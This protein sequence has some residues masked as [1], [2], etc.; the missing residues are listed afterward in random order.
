MYIRQTILFTLNR[1]KVILLCLAFFIPFFSY[2]ED[3]SIQNYS[4]LALKKGTFYAGL[5]LTPQNASI[6]LEI[7]ETRFGINNSASINVEYFLAN[8]LSILGYAALTHYYSTSKI[9]T[10]FSQTERRK[11][12][13]F[14]PLLGIGVA[15]YPKFFQI[16]P[17]HSSILYNIGLFGVFNRSYVKGGFINST[18]KIEISD[19]SVNGGFILQFYPKNRFHLPTSRFSGQL[20]FSFPTYYINRLESGFDINKPPNKTRLEYSNFITFGIKYQLSPLAKQVNKEIPEKFR[21][22]TF[23]QLYKEKSIHAGLGLNWRPMYYENN[24]SSTTI[25]Y[26]VINTDLE[27]FIKRR[28]SVN[29]GYIGLRSSNPTDLFD[30]QSSDRLSAF[31]SV[32]P[33]FMRGLNRFSFSSSLGLSY[34][35][36]KVEL[37]SNPN[38]LKNNFA[39]K[40]M[41]VFGAYTFIYK[42]LRL[43][44][45]DNHNFSLQFRSMGSVYTFQNLTK[46]R[47]GDEKFEPFGSGIARGLL[48]RAVYKLN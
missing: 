23:D 47:E 38:D 4:H 17:K 9:D 11:F 36:G 14:N 42:P 1:A 31:F 33:K 26:M 46:F 27:Y 5:G 45:Q 8:R 39:F 48:I 19:A 16:N 3:T 10:T 28:L 15:Y 25:N 43:F 21:I 32:Y 20:I 29:L 41:Q 13:S 7:N 18:N 34:F 40:T 44:K 22:T 2:S 12:S 24:T 30:I 35:N 6:Y 37:L